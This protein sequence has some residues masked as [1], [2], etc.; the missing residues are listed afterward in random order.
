ML[1]L[2][3]HTTANGIY[4][5]TLFTDLHHIFYNWS[6][7]RQVVLLLLG[8]IPPGSFSR[9]ETWLQPKVQ[10]DHQH[11][12]NKKR[13]CSVKAQ[14][15]ATNSFVNEIILSF[16]PHTAVMMGT[17][18]SFQFRINS[19]SSSILT[20]WISLFKFSSVVPVFTHTAW[21]IRA[22]TF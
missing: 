16:T 8:T 18:S 22:T 17:P 5:Q 14:P 2:R 15:S 9:K 4:C 10:K 21:F 7:S 12:Y 6:P 19:R 13:N 11:D 20:C 1:T 3:D